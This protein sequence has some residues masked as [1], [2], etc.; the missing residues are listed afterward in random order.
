MAEL[1]CN[2]EKMAK[3]KKEIQQV[4]VKDGTT[5][6]SHFSK[7]PFLH[8]VVKET[9]RLHPPAPFLVPHKSNNDVEIDG[10]IVPK[11]AQLLINV[12][13]IGR[14]SSVW[15][16]PNLFV[17]E[18]FLESEKSFI[19]S[20]FELIPFG[21]GRRMCPGLPVAER[22]M[23]LILATLVHNFD[24][25]LPNGLKPQ[26]ID[27]SESYGLTLKKAEPLRPI[28]TKHSI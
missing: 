26:D 5:E 3:S 23:H 20:D 21:A 17:P 27:M 14:D 8:A 22:T 2:P 28:P 7:L 12:W 18:R 13:A 9:L 11:S 4:L 15:N 25:T 16:K 6:E 10:L 24:W 1:I 19:G